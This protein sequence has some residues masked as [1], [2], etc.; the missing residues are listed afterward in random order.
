MFRRLHAIVTARTGRSR[1]FELPLL[2]PGPDD[3]LRNDAALGGHRLQRAAD[4]PGPSATAAGKGSGAATAPER[5]NALSDGSSEILVFVDP[6]GGPA[7]VCL[8]GDGSNAAGA[9]LTCE[10]AVSPQG[11]PRGG[12]PGRC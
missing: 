5:A 8:G 2:D 3:G 11:F 4:R 10:H 6:A 9:H 7:G 12:A 1:A